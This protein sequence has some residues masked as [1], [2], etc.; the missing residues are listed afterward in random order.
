MVGVLLAESFGAKRKSIFSQ[1]SGV[2][3]LIW[4]SKGQLNT[5]K[6]DCAVWQLRSIA[7]TKYLENS[8]RKIYFLSK[9]KVVPI[10]VSGEVLIELK[11]A[12]A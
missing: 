3:L 9:L 12:E 10:M 11:M 4:H 2:F 8:N 5:W 7:L 6:N 1:I